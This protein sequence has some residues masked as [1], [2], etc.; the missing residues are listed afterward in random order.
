M[1][2]ALVILAAVFVYAFSGTAAPAT[3]DLAPSFR[4]GPFRCVPPA[5]HPHGPDVPGPHCGRL[6]PC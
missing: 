6:R 1:K 3:T 4:C 2:R 5:P